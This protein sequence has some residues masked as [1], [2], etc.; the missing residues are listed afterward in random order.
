MMATIWP[1][2]RS[3]SSCACASA[4]MLMRQYGHQWPRWNVTATGPLLEQ[5]FEADQATRHV[6]QQEIR[7]RL[8]G[9][10]RRLTGAARASR[11]DQPVDRRLKRRA[12]RARR[13]RERR[14]PLV[15]RRIHVAASLESFAQWFG[16]TGSDR[17][18]A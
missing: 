11:A 12:A 16:V 13:A 17:R 6:G 5:V 7:H 2:P 9:L 3:I 8:A 4:L 14:E 10:G 18:V 1:P 15:Q